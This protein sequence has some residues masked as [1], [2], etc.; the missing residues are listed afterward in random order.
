LFRRYSLAA[1]RAYPHLFDGRRERPTIDPTLGRKRLTDFRPYRGQLCLAGKD[2][3]S[4]EPDG[5]VRRCGRGASMGNLLDGSVRFKKKAKPCDRSYCFY[6]CEKLTA[7]AEAQ[8]AR[9]HPLAAMTKRIK[10]AFADAGA[11]GAAQ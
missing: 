1:E 6:F 11:E 5:N 4:L 8:W 7:R 3:V 10:R 2:F 9:K